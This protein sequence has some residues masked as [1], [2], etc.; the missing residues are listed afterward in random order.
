MKTVKKKIL[1]IALAL[2]MLA[3]PIA[4]ALATKP[5]TVITATLTIGGNPLDY[6]EARLLGK[7]GNWITTYTD[8]PFTLTGDIEG[9]GVYNGK[10]LMKIADTPMGFKIQ[11]S[12]GWY[13]MN[14]EVGDVS[15]ELTIRLPGNANLLIIVGGTDGLENLHGTGTLTP[16]TMLQYTVTLNAH[17]DP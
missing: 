12:D 1:V 11:A 10:W 8:A 5:T 15:G 9:T 13:T 6:A 2:A 7:S 3:L 16:I 17:W 4:S 14:V